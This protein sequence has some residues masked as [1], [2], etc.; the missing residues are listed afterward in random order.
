[1]IFSFFATLKMAALHCLLLHFLS[2]NTPSF[3]NTGW[4]TSFSAHVGYS[5]LLFWFLTAFFVGI[6]LAFI[7]TLQNSGV[8]LTLLH[9]VPLLATFHGLFGSF[10]LNERNNQISS[11]LVAVLV[12]FRFLPVDAIR[13][14]W[15]DYKAQKI[16]RTLENEISPRP[17]CQ[18]NYLLSIPG[19]IWKM[20]HIRN[21]T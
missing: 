17:F 4:A 3:I 21:S 14:S 8:I 11:C 20:Y 6:G 15:L 5:I 16:F 1:M 13:P 10:A 19:F 18:S 2:R 9:W 12:N 7:S